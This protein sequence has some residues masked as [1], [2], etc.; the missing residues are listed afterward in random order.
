MQTLVIAID[1]PVGSGKSTVAQALAARLGFGYLDTGAMYRAV[2]LKALREG[3]DMQDPAALTRVARSCEIELAGPPDAPRVLLDGED[4]SEAIRSL[5]VTNSAYGPSQ[6][7][8]VRARMVELQREAARGPLVAEGRDMGT[9][10]FPKSPAKFYLDASV[11]ERASRRHREHAAKG[12]AISLEELTRQIIRRDRRDSGRAASPLRA[13]D[14]AIRIDTTHRSVEDV[15][16]AIIAV[17][18]DK[19]LL[20]GG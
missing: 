8:G 1:G 3:V 17:L 19:G 18:S 15:V 14:D 9:V 20:R 6:T 12:E 10:V 5:A 4:V 7:P 2:T 13:A 16:S 11:A